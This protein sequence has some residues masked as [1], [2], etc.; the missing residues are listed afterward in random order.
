[1]HGNAATGCNATQRA[2]EFGREYIKCK[3]YTLY[4]T[5]FSSDIGVQLISYE[6]AYHL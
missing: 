5:M 3:Y 4:G 6:N 1:M 2:N